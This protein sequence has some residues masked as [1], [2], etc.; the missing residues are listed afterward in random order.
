M[1]ELLE[2][3][4]LEEALRSFE[5]SDLRSASSALLQALGYTYSCYADFDDDSVEKFIYYSAPKRVYFSN[6]EK[7]YLSQIVE[8]HIVGEATQNDLLGTGY[9]HKKMVLISVEVSCIKSSRSEISYYITQSLSKLFDDYIFVIFKQ[10]NEIE[11]GTCGDTG[12]VYISDWIN[13][14]E[15][16]ISELNAVLQLAPSNIIG[17][18]TIKDY[19]DDISFALS[20]EYLK[21]SES[22]EYMVYEC[23]PNT[24]D[25]FF[26]TTISR[27]TINEFASKSRNYYLEIYGDDYIKA[28]E[29]LVEIANNDEDWTFFELDD[30]IT[31]D[32]QIDLD[33]ESYSNELSHDDDNV[34]EYS[35]IDR[36]ILSDPVKL[37]KYLDS[38]DR[39]ATNNER[40]AIR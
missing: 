1:Y 11:F 20:R 14:V 31:P 30:F 38:L 27:A 2:A 6:Q 9:S 18:K 40:L 22:Y 26:E 19:Y 3:F 13:T 4:D 10:Q 29:S 35:E 33:S 7:L 34:I 24:N 37:L 25:D 39:N 21:R 12:I 17:A 15:P 23:F 28:D 32:A 8:L 16:K 36:D 5:Y